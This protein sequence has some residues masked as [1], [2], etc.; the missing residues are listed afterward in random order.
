MILGRTAKPPM[1]GAALCSHTK[2]NTRSNADVL[3]ACFTPLPHT[4]VHIVAFSVGSRIMH[5]LEETKSQQRGIWLASLHDNTG[6]T[7]NVES[8][9]CWCK[10][11]SSFFIRSVS[12]PACFKAFSTVLYIV[13]P[14]PRTTILRLQ[15]LWMSVLRRHGSMAKTCR[16]AAAGP[17]GPGIL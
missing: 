11:L 15:S 7:F 1:I 8:T 12:M 9:A 16:N 6:Q 17:A 3:P 14:T 4:M 2:S 13:P 5:I 10:P